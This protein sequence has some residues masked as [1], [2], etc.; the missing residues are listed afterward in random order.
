MFAIWKLVV[1]HGWRY[2]DFMELSYK[3]SKTISSIFFMTHWRYLKTL[4]SLHRSLEQYSQYS[5]CM[6]IWINLIMAK[7]Y[8]ATKYLISWKNS[9]L[10][11]RNVAL[12]H[13]ARLIPNA[14]Q[15]A[16]TTSG[17]A[18]DENFVAIA[19]SWDR[20]RMFCHLYSTKYTPVNFRYTLNTQGYVV[21]FDRQR[22]TYLFP[23]PYFILILSVVCFSIIFLI[24]V[25]VLSSLSVFSFVLVFFVFVFSV[26]K[27]VFTPI[28]RC[29]LFP[30]HHIYKFATHMNLGHISLHFMPL[31]QSYYITVPVF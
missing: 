16:R 4:L 19:I 25:Y 27:I 18:G 23:F 29:T 20:L 9:C 2:A 11:L 3:V 15:N 7:I 24:F 28:A 30:V 22:L 6:Y 17:S 14:P 5:Y 13:L 12:S 1:R 8:Y 31:C 21:C 26:F 10:S